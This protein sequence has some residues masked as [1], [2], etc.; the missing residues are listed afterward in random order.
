MKDIESLLSARMMM[1]SRCVKPCEVVYDIGT[2]HCYIPIYL[3]QKGVC[4]KAVATDIRQGPIDKALENI[5]YF[6]LSE[7]IT[8]F[9]SEGISHVGKKANIVI[10]G[11]GADVIINILSEHIDYAKDAEQIVIQCQSRTEHLRSFLWENGFSIKK[12]DL[13]LERAKVYN[14]FSAVYTGKAENFTHAE[15]VLS[16]DL[17]D[18]KHPLLHSYINKHLLKLEDMI[19]GMK[20]S[21][22]SY[23][24]L[25]QIKKEM[26]KI[27]EESK[28]Y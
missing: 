3:I 16:K 13:I 22:Q 5:H 9:V 20:K 23:Q 2:D 14:A 8:A 12:E 27:H 26:E 4:K 7:E 10:S 1:V 21:N 6:N 25:V 11:M 28:N 17:I 24:Q 15:A 18:K 19:K